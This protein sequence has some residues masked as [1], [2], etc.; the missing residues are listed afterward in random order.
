MTVTRRTLLKLASALPAGSFF[1]MTVAH[2]EEIT[3]AH[4]ITL[5]DDIKY[6][7][8]FKHFDYVRPDAPKGGKVR[9]YALGSFDSLNSFTFKGNSTAV[10]AG[11]N[12]ALITRAL[13]EPTTDY[14]LIASGIWFPPDKSRVVYRLRPE[15]RFHDGTAISPS[16]II[17]SMDARK[18]VHPRWDAYWKN[19][20]K[21]E[22]TGDHDVTFI[23]DQPGNRELPALAGQIS[24]LPKHWWTGKD[25]NG[26]QRDISEPSLEAPLGSG[27][28]KIGTVKPG[29]SISL[30]RVDDYWGKDLP[31]NVGQDNFDEIEY[32][33]FADQTVAFEAFKGDQYDYRLEGSAKSWATGYDF[34]AVKDGRVIKEKLVFEEVQPIQAWVL[35]L[36]RAKFQDER[37]R[38]AFNLAFDFEWTRQ[39]LF[40][41]EYERAR[42]IFNHSEFEAKGLPSP[43]ELALLEP[44]KAHLPPT[45]FTAEYSN[46]L[47]DTPAAK[48]KNL[49]EASQLLTEAGWVQAKDGGKTV[50]KN[51]KGE[52]LAVEFM[53]DSPI[54]E[55]IALPYAKNLELLGI[56]STIRTIDPAQ[57]EKRTQD[58]D[59]D[60]TNSIWGQSLSPGNEQRDFWGSEAADRKGSSNYAGIKNKAIDTLIEK[61]IFVNSRA[62]LVT[63]C[64]ALDRA[65]MANNYFVP[66][67]YGAYDRIARWDRFSHPESMPKYATGFPT[68][69]WWDEAKAKKVKG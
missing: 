40:Y 46:P 55:R 12:E 11:A 69:W 8:D 18:K 1:G 38:R 28:Y 47:N 22:Q 32:I 20:V 62:E 51:T 24:A 30:V 42:S 15:A 57:V 21:V 59:F 14:G 39:N 5:Y 33:Y 27:A 61:L 53:L 4:A 9:L 65:V 6:P 48:R 56:T 2:A 60:I 13:D 67:W 68:I 25:A 64:R 44:L 31:V 26:K 17:W 35:N 19:I 3:F 52:I 37:V 7:P 50:L 63:A 45:V 29:Q 58:F 16:D 23:F 41:G 36:R 54:F 43:E 10:G 34:P 49:R 66:M